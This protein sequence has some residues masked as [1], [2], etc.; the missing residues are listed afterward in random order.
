MA[1]KKITF[2]VEEEKIIGPKDDVL[3][4]RVERGKLP[5]EYKERKMPRTPSPDVYETA[6][7]VR[8][9]V[10]EV[11]RVLKEAGL[12]QMTEDKRETCLQ[13]HRDGWPFSTAVFNGRDLFEWTGGQES[14]DFKGKLLAE[15]LAELLPNE[16]IPRWTLLSDILKEFKE[17]DTK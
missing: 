15:I 4:L 9:Y 5:S 11:W 16:R 1:P 3:T 14:R 2:I 17:V 10:E 6:F 7:K 8:E 13:C 12:D